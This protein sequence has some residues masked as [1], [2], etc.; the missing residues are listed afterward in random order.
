MFRFVVGVLEHF[1]LAT[2]RRRSPMLATL[3][4]LASLAVSVIQMVA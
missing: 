4:G 1:A 2:L 3:I